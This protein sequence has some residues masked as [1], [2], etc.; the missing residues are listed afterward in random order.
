MADL[1]DKIPKSDLK[2]LFTF[3]AQA[4]VDSIKNPGKTSGGELPKGDSS[5]KPFIVVFRHGISKDNVAKVHSG[6]RDATELTKEGEQQAAELTE[7]LKDIKFDYYFQSDQV[8]AQQTL[9]IAMGSR[10]FEPITDWRLK[11]RNYGDLN[12]QSKE[13]WL[14]K[15]MLRAVLYRRSWDYPPPGGESVQMVYYRVL[16][17]IKELEYVLK[18]EQASAVISCS[19]NSMRPIRAYFEKLSEHEIPTINNPTGKDY[20]LYNLV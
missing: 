18:K 3:N 5:K 10:N 7:K 14:K 2:D 6:W 8:R 17:F 4:A 20:C 1:L 13:E 16:S 15:D 9:K 11:E 19:N 12:G